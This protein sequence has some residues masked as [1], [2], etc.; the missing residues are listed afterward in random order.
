MLQ[1]ERSLGDD[2]VRWLE[3][4]QAKICL[5]GESTQHLLDLQRRADELN[6]PNFLVQDAGRT[7]IPAGSFTVLSIFGRIA[8]VNQVTGSLRLL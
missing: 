2:M 3:F 6:L 1:N 5:R 4:G 8:T 7:Q